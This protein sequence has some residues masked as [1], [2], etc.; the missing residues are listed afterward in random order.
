M[1]CSKQWGIYPEISECW[2]TPKEDSSRLTSRK[3]THSTNMLGSSISWKY[4]YS[5]LP[6][7]SDYDRKWQVSK[8]VQTSSKTNFLSV[9]IYTVW[10]WRKT[11]ILEIRWK[12]NLWHYGE[13][14]SVNISDEKWNWVSLRLNK[15]I[16]TNLQ[17]RIW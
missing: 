17:K 13:V 3:W 1:L 10:V 9:R 7:T 16:N 15:R 11:R 14:W 12:G 5:L 8:I 2:V 6:Y 4:W